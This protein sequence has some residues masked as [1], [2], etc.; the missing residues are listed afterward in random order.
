MNNIRN[1]EVQINTENF[2]TGIYFYK[3]S[4]A[5]GFATGKLVVQK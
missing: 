5:V 1:D 4:G 3:L 2:A